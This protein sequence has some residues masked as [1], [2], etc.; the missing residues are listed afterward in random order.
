M[1]PTTTFLTELNFE[2]KL[3]PREL[4]GLKRP[5]LGTWLLMKDS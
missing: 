3:R 5:S 4:T 1:L 2:G